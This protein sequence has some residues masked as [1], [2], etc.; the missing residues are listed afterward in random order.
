MLLPLRD[1][2]DSPLFLKSRPQILAGA[3]HLEDTS[4][5]WVHSSE[6]LQIAPLLRGGELLLSGGQSLLNLSH[7]AQVSYV[8]SLADRNVAA[9]AIET[10]GLAKGI[11]QHLIDAAEAAG[12]PLIELRATVPFVEMAEE[13][14]R[15]IVSQ[16]AL[17]LQRADDISQRLAQQ[18]AT[19]GP[20]LSPLV[21]LIAESLSVNA[22]LADLAGAPLAT[23]QRIPKE[24][25][26]LEVFSDIF[27][28]N[29]VA[30]R[31]HLKTP[32]AAEREL[33]NT[34]A[35]RLG[36]I[37][38]LA[39]SQ[40]H[41]PSRSQIADSAL[42]QAII[43][44]SSA[45]EIRELG[46]QVGLSMA[47][48]VVIIIFRSVDLGRIR[49]MH[50]RILRR[51]SPEIKTYM[52]SEYLYGLIPLN[53]VSARMDRKRLVGLLREDIHSLALQGAMGP[54]VYDA[55]HG[56]WSL[57]EAMLAEQ[58][59][60]S[61][62][63]HAGGLRDCDNVVLERFCARELNAKAVDTFIHELLAELL[64]HDAQRG[65]SL[66]K[67]L[68]TWLTSG[69]NSTATAATLYLERQTLHKRLTKI[70]D[71]LGG[72]PRGTSRMA[73]LHLATRLAQS[74]FIPAAKN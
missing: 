16:Q 26:V 15:F 33:L 50:E 51:H 38:A 44:N 63:A 1:V 8:E 2:L 11:G 32:R 42:M 3:A 23:S 60:T 59:A 46:T 12:L 9:L 48:P 54:G 5:R 31:L 69:C 74:P 35:E 73:A 6:V 66:V 56:Y 25:E 70:F 37:L 41:R 28:S 64:E 65:S 55:T 20:N 58:L 34:I 17:A 57:R 52:D 71:I 40:H 62:P 27:V 30:A 49:G 19:A 47:T 13:I 36:S 45:P 4:V 10:A 39:L 22:E 18:I 14:N 72:D 29:M 24:L 21:E 61:L 68:E 67:T 53:P 7:A 43:R